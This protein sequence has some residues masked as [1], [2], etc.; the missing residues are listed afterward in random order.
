MDNH[1]NQLAI[2]AIVTRLP[3][4]ADLF[5]ARGIDFCCGGHR[6][7][8]PVLAEQ[9]ID[10]AEI[11]ARLE[12]LEKASRLALGRTDY[13][14]MSASE[15]TS[16]I[17][18]RHHTYLNENLPL[19]GEI[20]GAVLK[21]HGRNHPEL[22]KLHGLYGQLRT[23]LEQHLIKEEELLFPLLSQGHDT[24]AEAVRLAEEIKNEH[25]AAGQT[26]KA[27]RRLSSDYRVP[28][29]ACPTYARLYK[30][31]VELE[32]DIFQHIHLEN[33]ILLA[34]QHNEGDRHA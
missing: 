32:S 12:E 10:A 5:K 15:L 3:A 25:E 1:W 9:Q 8:G 19:I 16:H 33:N 20:L 31:L 11:R 34:E 7:L 14:A 30:A 13:A 27:M 24:D 21:A 17:E 23:E 26:L 4:A 29:D 18:V 28:D 2:G 22:F 6:L